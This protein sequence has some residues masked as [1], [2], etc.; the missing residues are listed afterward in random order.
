MPETVAG[1]KCK[2]CNTEQRGSF[3]ANCGAPQSIPRI[4]GRFI[5]MELARVF[6]FEKGIFYTI[7]ELLLRPGQSV[8]HFIH[9]D[10]SSLFKPI[11]FV[12]LCSVI[13]VV[14][15]RY[16][17]FEDGYVNYSGL[18]WGDSAVTT[19]MTW[20]TANYGLANVLM[21]FLI[22]LWVKV[23]FKKYPY[24]YF[25]I[26]ILLYF[27]MGIGMLIYAFLGLAE[28]LIK[29]PIVD[30]GSILAFVY[31]VWV[32]GQF[33]DGKRWGSYVKALFSYLLGMITFTILAILLGKMIDW[34]V[35]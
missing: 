29:I 12:I 32:I 14:A 10:R 28:Y 5:L 4:N 17:Q 16:F 34:M 3:C 23:F 19:I 30:K 25:E 22:A 13:Y 9:V 2:R 21:A 31:I 15:Q 20:V 6:N 35:G 26:L 7:R 18:G 33:F 27:I 24:N 8:Q 1:K 11:N